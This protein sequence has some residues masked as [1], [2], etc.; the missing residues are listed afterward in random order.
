MNSKDKVKVAILG[1]AFN[2]PTNG[3]IQLAEFV[4]ENTNIQE[5]W[6]T[7]CYSHMHNKKMERP[8][9]R[10]R[11]CAIA[12]RRN[13]KIHVFDYE[14]RNKL[15]GSTYEL[16]NKL[17]NDP[18]LDVEISFIIGLDNANNFNTWYKSDKLKEI[19]K[20]IVVPRKGVKTPDKKTWYSKEPH[21]FLNIETDITECSSTKARDFFSSNGRSKM[22][23]FLDKE[24]QW[25]IQ[26][27]NLYEPSE[28]IRDI[29]TH[30]KKRGWIWSSAAKRLK[31]KDRPSWIQV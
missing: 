31:D 5:V 6:L 1:G 26:D 17:Y 11:M 20:F 30:N 29:E 15:N 27:Q 28:D 16:A 2:P 3:H 25:Y 9:H 24:V 7:P 4:L 23:W 12:A 22:I 18:K 8:I 19:A 10:L 13:E 14:I 21:T